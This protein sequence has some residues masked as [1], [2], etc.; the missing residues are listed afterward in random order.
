MILYCERLEVSGQY[1]LM[2]SGCKMYLDTVDT[3]CLEWHLRT[4]E[5]PFC[6]DC[7]PASADALPEHLYLDADSYWLRLDNRWHHIRSVEVGSSGWRLMVALR[8]VGV[9][10]REKSKSGLVQLVISPP[11][12]VETGRSEVI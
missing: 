3:G 5:R 9:C 11:P 1:A 6:F 7:D 8:A 12:I 10:L 4:G 2:C